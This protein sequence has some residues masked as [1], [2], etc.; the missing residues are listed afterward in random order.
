VKQLHDRSKPGRPEPEARE[1]QHPEEER[2]LHRAGMRKVVNASPKAARE[3]Q[4]CCSER[5]ANQILALVYTPA[6]AM[7]RMG[8]RLAMAKRMAAAPRR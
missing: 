5:T 7:L 8:V 4:P 6:T 3:I 1:Q 2:Y